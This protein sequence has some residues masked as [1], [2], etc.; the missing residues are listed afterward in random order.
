MLPPPHP[1]HPVSRRHRHAAMPPCQF[2]TGRL[3]VLYL[4]TEPPKQS[5]AFAE[6]QALDYAVM[7]EERRALLAQLQEAGGAAGLDAAAAAKAEATSGSSQAPL[8]LKARVPSRLD[9]PGGDDAA[10][11]GRISGAFGAGLGGG[12][13]GVGSR[14]QQQARQL[15]LAL[16]LSNT[17]KATLKVSCGKALLWLPTS[18]G[19]GK[20]CT[21]QKRCVPNT[22]PT[23]CAHMC[24]NRYPV[25]LQLFKQVDFCCLD[26]D[27]VLVLALC[28]LPAPG[29]NH[30]HLGTPP[31]G[32]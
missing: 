30:Q 8:V 14:W 25:G 24:M 32:N 15:T 20:Q 1:G 29:R 9:A 28:M 19:L 21:P 3:S 11:M 27:H 10:G 22:C 23:Q 16:L 4:G 5:I 17:T 7:E 26:C 18:V 12:I 13:G 6:S 31:S 2:L